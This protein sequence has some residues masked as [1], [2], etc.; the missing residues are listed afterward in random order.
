MSPV[1]QST[2]DKYFIVL[3][4][5]ISA[6]HSFFRD[7]TTS[8]LVHTAQCIYLVVDLVESYYYHRRKLERKTEIYERHRFTHTNISLC[9]RTTIQV[10]GSMVKQSLHFD[11]LS[12]RK[13]AKMTS[14]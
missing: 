14:K 7:P 8:F 6:L 2:S 10:G 5:L 3:V 9:A 1:T 11:Q 12:Y 13:W 4:G